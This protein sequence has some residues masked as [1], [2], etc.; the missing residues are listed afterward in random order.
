MAGGKVGVQKM[1]LGWREGSVVR[2]TDCLL[3]QRS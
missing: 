1:E 3:F 2:S